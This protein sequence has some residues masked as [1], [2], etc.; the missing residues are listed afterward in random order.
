MSVCH[1]SAF[2]PLTRGGSVYQQANDAAVQVSEA[3]DE[4]L[5][6]VLATQAALREEVATLRAMQASPSSMLCSPVLMVSLT[7]PS[8]ALLRQCGAA[9]GNSCDCPTACMCQSA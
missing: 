5:S 1:G 4:E 8:S 9:W 3:K 7:L 2:L 6:R